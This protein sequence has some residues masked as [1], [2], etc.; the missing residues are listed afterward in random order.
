MKIFI[1]ENILNKSIANFT[2][3]CTRK[4]GNLLPFYSTHGTRSALAMGPVY[5]LNHP[6]S[7]FG[8]LLLLDDLGKAVPNLIADKQLS[9]RRLRLEM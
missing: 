6:D 2:K 4:M 7:L 9:N 5:D 8:P 1:A 3:N